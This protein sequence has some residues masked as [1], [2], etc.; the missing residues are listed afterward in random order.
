MVWKRFT[1]LFHHRVTETQRKLEILGR[2]LRKSLGL[3]VLAFSVTLCRC[4]ENGVLKDSA[5]DALG[6]EW[7]IE[8]D[9]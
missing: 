3:E 1:N 6:Q 4:G 5:D 7:G 8:V 2:W 9:Q